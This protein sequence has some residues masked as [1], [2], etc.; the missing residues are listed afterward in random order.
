MRGLG[1][2]DVRTEPRAMHGRELLRL[3]GRLL[4]GG[5]GRI[6]GWLGRRTHI[7]LAEKLRE[8]GWGNHARTGRAGRAAILDVTITGHRRM[9]HE[10]LD[11]IGEQT[12]GLLQLADDGLQ[13]EPV[14]TSP[15][16]LRY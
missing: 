6:A 9:T 16:P 5:V 10:I 15:R 12:D 11:L 1:S 2:R 8:L 13:I 14:S 3:W 4:E 7:R